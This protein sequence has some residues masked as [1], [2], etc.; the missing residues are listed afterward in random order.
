MRR[1][2]CENSIFNTS[3]K[4]SQDVESDISSTAS[5]SNNT[6]SLEDI[7]QQAKKF[8]QNGQTV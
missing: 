4:L 5:Q 7:M 8:D 3:S 6:L 2:E 1:D